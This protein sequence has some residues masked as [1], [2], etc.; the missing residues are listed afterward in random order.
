MQLPVH[1]AHQTGVCILLHFVAMFCEV[2]SLHQL[3]LLSVLSC[4]LPPDNT[5][6]LKTRNRLILYVYIFYQSILL[7]KN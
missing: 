1:L 4:L 6:L 2:N 5:L 3:L 7:A